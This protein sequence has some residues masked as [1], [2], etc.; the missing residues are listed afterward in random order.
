MKRQRTLGD[1]ERINMS[2]KKMYLTVQQIDKEDHT[3]LKLNV[4]LRQHE[5]EAVVS[6]LL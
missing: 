3:L 5:K 1:I 2:V 6:E 4:L